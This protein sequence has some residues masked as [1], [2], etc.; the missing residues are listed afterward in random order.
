MRLVCDQSAASVRAFFKM[1]DR[2]LKNI[3]SWGQRGSS[4]MRASLTR[5]K[6]CVSG[7]HSLHS[8]TPC[9][10]IWINSTATVNRIYSLNTTNHR[11]LFSKRAC[12]KAAIND[13]LTP[14]YFWGIRVIH[15]GLLG[16]EDVMCPQ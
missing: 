16:T 11:L 2:L 14:L 8:P 5:Y 12:V 9:S 10:V 7:S 13:S 15:S 3:Y 1:K 6:S 4:I